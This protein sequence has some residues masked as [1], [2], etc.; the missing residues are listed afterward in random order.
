M[1]VLMQ[2][3]EE[4]ERPS[5]PPSKPPP[6]VH[7]LSDGHVIY[8]VTMDETVQEGGEKS[9]GVEAKPIPVQ[10][11]KLELVQVQ[12][13]AMCHDTIFVRLLTLDFVPL[14][15]WWDGSAQCLARGGCSD[16]LCLFCSRL[17]MAAGG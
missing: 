1:L 15:E 2:I 3:K 10:V 12:H 13:G 14:A 16:R 17:R 6:T 11:S 7:V 5:N 9:G 4:V 8:H